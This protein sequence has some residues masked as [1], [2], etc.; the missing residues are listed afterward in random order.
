MQLTGSQ[1]CAVF[2]LAMGEDVATDMLG[3]MQRQE[4]A[5]ITEAMASLPHVPESEV[6]A[7]LREARIFLETQADGICADRALAGRHFTLHLPFPFRED[8]SEVKSK[9]E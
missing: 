4:V 2:L 7:I 8:F 5:R 3:R 9:S 6:R 1:R